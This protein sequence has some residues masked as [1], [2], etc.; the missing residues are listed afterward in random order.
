MR[1]SFPG[2][3]HTKFFVL[4]SLLQFTPKDRRTIRKLV[5]HTWLKLTFRIHHI[6]LGSS[7]IP[8]SFW[9]SERVPSRYFDIK[10][11]L[12]TY[13]RWNKRDALWASTIL[14]NRT[15]FCRPKNSGLRAFIGGNVAG[16]K[17]K[18]YVPLFCCVVFDMWG[19]Y[20]E[21]LEKQTIPAKIT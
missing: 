18:M 11:P 21:S 15:R 17:R 7:D 4:L 20:L 12:C 3:Y 6:L 8:G 1:W 10:A 16:Y 13:R 9:V 19:N 2:S 14:G 5:F